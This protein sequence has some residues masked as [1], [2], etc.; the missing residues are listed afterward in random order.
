MSDADQIKGAIR[1]AVD[2]RT[3]ADRRWRAATDTLG[4]QLRA[5]RDIG[6]PVAELSRTAGLT[7]QAVYD[8]IER[9][10]KLEQGAPRGPQPRRGRRA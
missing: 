3:T 5:G 10:R 2:D 4:H 1:A 6:I 7:R 9:D 8:L